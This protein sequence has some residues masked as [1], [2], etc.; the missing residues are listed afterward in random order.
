[1]TDRLKNMRGGCGCRVVL[2]SLLL[3]LSAWTLA[4]GGGR[5]ADTAPAGEWLAALVDGRETLPA[6]LVGPDGF[7]MSEEVGDLYRAREFRTLW[8]SN[9]SLRPS[10]YL[11][12]DRLRNAAEHGLCG[13]D[14]LLAPLEELLANRA[15][16]VRQQKAVPSLDAAVLD[17]FLTQAFFSYATH[18]V[19]GQI[20]PAL[21]HVDWR[22]R[23]RKLDL[24]RLLPP[25][26]DG[27]SLGTLLGELIPPHPE[28]RALMKALARQRELVTRGGWPTV[29]S[30]PKGAKLRPGDIDPRLPAIRARL[31]ATGE[32]PAPL[33]FER[34]AYGTGTLAAVRRFQERHGLEPDGVIGQRTLAA[35]NVTAEE[36]VRQIELN[37]ERWR[38]MPRDLGRRHIRV[39]IADFSLKVIEDGQAVLEMP[40][41]VGTP[42][43]RT[44]V[45]SSQMSYLEFAPTWT[46]PAT[47]LR[48]DKLPAIKKNP[49]F[50][51]KNHFHVIRR[52][53]Q[54][55]TPQELAAINWHAVEAERFPGSLRMDPGPWNPLGRVKFMFPNPYNV[56]LHDT[57]ERW[58]FDRTLRTF[59][60]G[61]IRIGQPVEL[62]RYLLRDQPQWDEER[63]QQALE[64]NTPMQVSIDP[65][66]THI[67][68]WTAWVDSDGSTRFRTDLYLR[69]LDLE[70]ALRPLAQDPGRSRLAGPRPENGRPRQG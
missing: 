36:R 32:L 37:L 68:Y 41:I 29:P 34:N 62:A 4:W 52:T 53:G 18:L 33:P 24:V 30:L 50:L 16:L 17:L 57:N 3:C 55:L 49:A 65:I 5:V 11:L 20:D 2:L 40:V 8:Q 69:D 70:T 46:V 59:S 66:P 47:V 10:A 21:V 9:G 31:L 22:A 60:S 44:P 12:V 15:G 14:Y 39:N 23:R 67:Q 26:V 7:V 56:Y 13:E 42:Y 58:L 35:L 6:G 64:R 61:C 45:F 51:S 54:A 28:Y 38:W 48:E 25:A 27:E 19:E 43:R 1:M 63:L